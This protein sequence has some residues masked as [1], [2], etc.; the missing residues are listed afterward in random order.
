MH[1]T[2]KA[3]AAL[4]T[5]CAPAL[6]SATPC[7]VADTGPT[8]VPLT[9]QFRLCDFS[10]STFSPKTMR[11]SYASGDSVIRVTGDTVIADVHMV[12]SAQPG[13]HY[14]V[15]VIQLPRPSAATCGPGDPGVVTAGL[16][17]DAAGQGQVTLRNGIQRT[18]TGVWVNVTRP[19]QN[20]QSP[21]EFYTSQIVSPV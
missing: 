3:C 19:S 11:T 6:S 14:E 12:N 4:A 21:E 9:P 13:S 18:A 2:M 17:L 15:A 10:P 16:D 5:L 20:S 7:A 8:L 1:P